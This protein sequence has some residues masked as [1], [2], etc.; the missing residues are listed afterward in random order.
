MA[1]ED[2]LHS[3]HNL[4]H[5]LK[6]TALRIINLEGRFKWQQYCFEPCPTPHLYAHQEKNI[7]GFMINFLKEARRQ[8][9]T[10]GESRPR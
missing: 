1:K 8:D 9:I 3:T 7:V 4:S 10:A 5:N 2:I 6:N